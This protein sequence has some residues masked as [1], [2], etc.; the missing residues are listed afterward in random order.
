MYEMCNQ[1]H[2]NVRT[3]RPS[4]RS[5]RSRGFTLVELLVVIGIIAVLIAILL[6]ALSSARE[7]ARTTA[8]LS[9]L[10]QI[11]IASVAYAQANK[12]Y[13]VPA[14]AQSTN[15][16]NGTKADA[17]NYATVLVNDKYLS[18][19]S[20]TNLSEGVSAVPSV[21]RCPSG[22][23]DFMYNQFSD[24]N[25]TAPSP[26]SRS[27]NVNNRPLRTVSQGTGVIVD[28]WYGINASINDT[29]KK[30]PCTRIE[31]A[32]TKVPKMSEIRDAT[33]MVFLFDGIFANIHYD[34]DRI[35]ARHGARKSKITNILFFDGHAQSFPTAGLPGGL[36]PN[37]A[38]TD[39][40]DP[41][42]LK[43]NN[44]GGLLWRLDQQL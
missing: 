24:T 42:K 30:T 40:F 7:A 38:G 9:N 39:L 23:D 2:N 20:L 3:P 5:G 12:N 13:T 1:P 10:R 6:P 36:G 8:C 17:E 34:A 33:R 31:S 14:Y 32:S 41:N 11:G 27:D 43:T 22:T 4:N 35:S 37:A 15:T 25:G 21:F 19:P 16:A 18:A 26:T 28:T 29:S 44:P